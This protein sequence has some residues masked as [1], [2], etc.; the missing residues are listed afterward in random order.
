MFHWQNGTSTRDGTYGNRHLPTLIVASSTPRLPHRFVLRENPAGQSYAQTISLHNAALTL[1]R[2]YPVTNVAQPVPPH[3]AIDRVS[4]Q[5]Q[6]GQEDARL[7]ASLPDGSQP[8]RGRGRPR[9]SKDKSTLARLKAQATVQTESGRSLPTR[10]GAGGGQNTA[11]GPERTVM[12]AWDA[13]VPDQSLRRSGCSP[14]KHTEQG[15]VI[16]VLLVRAY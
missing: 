9:G 3:L 15:A 8:R 11:L 1:S 10:G 5:S 12:R 13:G 6:N 14:E 16:W 7:G 4:V 2:D